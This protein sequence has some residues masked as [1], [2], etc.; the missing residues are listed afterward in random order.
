M[1]E[2]LPTPASPKIKTLKGFECGFS[3]ARM[4]KREPTHQQAL[5]SAG[6]EKV[7]CV[8]EVEEAAWLDNIR[9]QD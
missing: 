7:W 3:H 8:R 4:S 2:L 9:E 5:T 6:T 1:M